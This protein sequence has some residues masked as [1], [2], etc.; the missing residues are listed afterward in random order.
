MTLDLRRALFAEMAMVQVGMLGVQGA[1]LP[2][3]PMFHLM[4]PSS[5]EMWFLAEPDSDLVKSIDGLTTGTYCLIGRDHDLH[6]CLT[7]PMRLAPDRRGLERV[8]SISA[9]ALFP[10]GLS[11]LEWTPLQMRIAEASVWASPES[12][13]VAGMEMILPTLQGDVLDGAKKQ[14]FRF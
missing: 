7:G 10:G 4:V 1:A 9:E 12:A 5:P 11:N 8:W 2:L 6:A 13:V 14:V 3:Q